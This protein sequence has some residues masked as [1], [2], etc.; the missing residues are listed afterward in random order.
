M[1]RMQREF[2][3]GAAAAVAGGLLVAGLPTWAQGAVPPDTGNLRYELRNPSP[4]PAPTPQLGPEEPARIL[5][6]RPGVWR[7]P[8]PFY[9]YPWRYRRP[10]GIRR[11]YSGWQFE[12]SPGFYNP[13]YR[14]NWAYRWDYFGGYGRR[15]YNGP[16][17]P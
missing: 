7:R 16:W 17:P 4:T 1:K 9:R 3:W 5:G 13:Q 15:P 14:P 12:G 2:L 8:G 6:A 10:L 11:G